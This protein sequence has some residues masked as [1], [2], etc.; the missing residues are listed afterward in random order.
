MCCVEI[1]IKMRPDDP[2]PADKFHYPA[3]EAFLAEFNGRHPTVR[4]V[5][6]ISDDHW[7]KYPGIGAL[8]IVKLRSLTRGIRQE[9]QVPT[10]T[11]VSDAALLDQ[12]EALQEELVRIRDELKIL[13]AELRLRGIRPRP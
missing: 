11:P 12:H 3:R 4:E 5:A 8:T 6:C 7:L 9:L 13:K 1:E 2:F 10:L